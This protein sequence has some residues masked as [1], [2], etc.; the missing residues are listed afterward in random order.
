MLRED[1]YRV[2]LVFLTMVY[3]FFIFIVIPT[4]SS[5]VFFYYGLIFSNIIVLIMFYLGFVFK[6][7]KLLFVGL[8]IQILALNVSLFNIQLY[9]RGV[10]NTQELS[11]LLAY[12]STLPFYLFV[13]GSYNAIS[14]I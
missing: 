13:I 11:D 12:T 9:Y 3:L 1:I 10:F 5:E 4:L 14:Q 8:L 2:V 7:N 6:K